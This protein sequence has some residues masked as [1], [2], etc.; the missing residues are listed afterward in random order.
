[1]KGVQHNARK[2]TDAALGHLRKARRNPLLMWVHYYDMHPPFGQPAGE[3]SFGKSREDL[4]DAEVRMWDGEVTRL[5]HAIEEKHGKTGYILVIS[6][7]HGSAF[8]KNH[9]THSHGYDLHT[10][11]LHVPLLFCSPLFP[12]HRVGK[13]AVGLV[14]LAPTLV[15]LSGLETDAPYVGTSLVPLLFGDLEWPD[16]I[17]FHQF[18]LAEK[19]RKGQDP[20][21]AASARNGQYNYMWD[22]REDEYLLFEYGEDPAEETNL[23]DERPEMADSMDATLKTWLYRVRNHY[24]K[25]HFESDPTFDYGGSDGSDAIYH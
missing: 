6:A 23:F 17:I 15:N 3:M 18:Y 7:D 24:M 5:L 25:G 19:I 11:V 9:D 20:L 1:M 21:Y 2:M 16:R 10:A 13:T 22:R 4:Y 12:P 8:D 14:D